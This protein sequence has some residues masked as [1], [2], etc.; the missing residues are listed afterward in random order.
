MATFKVLRDIRVV[1]SRIQ[2]P[3]TREFGK[4]YS[5]LASGEGLGEVGNVSKDGNVWVNSNAEY[6]NGDPIS[7]IPVIDR[8]KRPIDSELG[9]GSQVELAFKVVKT[10]KGTYYNLACIKVLKLVKPFSV[11]DVFDDEN[12]EED[13]VLDA[14]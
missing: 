9:E 11:F 5:L 7:P 12:T 3:V 13:E 2:T 8:A 6:P 4:Q 14:F 10:S 1:N